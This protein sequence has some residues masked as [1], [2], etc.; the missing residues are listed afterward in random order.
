MRIM[1]FVTFCTLSSLLSITQ[2]CAVDTWA[3]AVLQQ[4][5]IESKL[6]NK[7]SERLKD[8]TQW[9]KFFEK[10]NFTAAYPQLFEQADKATIESFKTS[11]KKNLST[12]T[13][14]I[15]ALKKFK[16]SLESARRKNLEDLAVFFDATLQPKIEFKRTV[17]GK[18][19]TTTRVSTIAKS[20]FNN[21]ELATLFNNEYP[22]AAGNLAYTINSYVAMQ[23]Q[24]EINPRNMLIGMLAK[25]K[26]IVLFDNKTRE[27]FEKAYKDVITYQQTQIAAQ[28]K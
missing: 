28:K 8:L 1:S 10:T 15:N 14:Q 21:V 5:D 11:A 18:G 13:Q 7:P 23:Q 25:A 17:Q 26:S 12:L 2:L 6:A 24:Y 4:L 16:N 22:E 27:N 9:N 20:P 3:L 19:A